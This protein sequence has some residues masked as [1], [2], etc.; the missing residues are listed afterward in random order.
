MSQTDE[1]SN[2]DRPVNCPHS[3]PT[4]SHWAVNSAELCWTLSR[5]TLFILRSSINYKSSRFPTTAHFLKFVSPLLD[6]LQAFEHFQTEQ[7]E[8]SDSSNRWILKFSKKFGR[9]SEKPSKSQWVRKKLKLQ[10]FIFVSSLFKKI[11]RRAGG[12]GVRGS[13]LAVPNFRNFPSLKNGPFPYLCICFI[14]D[15]NRSSEHAL[16]KIMNSVLNAALN[17]VLNSASNS[18]QEGSNW[19]CSFIFSLMEWFNGIY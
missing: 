17:S 11:T 19:Q 5:S 13:L 18:E 16:R 7:F 3:S 8:I 6:S 12:L 9:P 14:S 1:R 2:R 15:R 10:C 4:S